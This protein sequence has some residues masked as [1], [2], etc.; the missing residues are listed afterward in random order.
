MRHHSSK[1][2]A[3]IPAASLNLS[4][5]LMQVFINAAAAQHARFNE[6]PALHMQKARVAVKHVMSELASAEQEPSLAAATAAAT[7]LRAAHSA[8]AA[9]ALLAS[10]TLGLAESSNQVCACV[11]RPPKSPQRP[12]W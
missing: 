5:W 11:H 9:E 12:L 8:I 10:L 6:A 2:L 1:S 7:A 3:P 4:V